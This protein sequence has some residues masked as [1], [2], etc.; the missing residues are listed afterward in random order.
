MSV[1][2]K[3]HLPSWLTKDF[4]EKAFRSYKKDESLEILSYNCVE[5]KFDNHFGSDIYCVEIIFKTP[6][7]S[8]S[9]S[10]V[11]VKLVTD[12]ASEMGEILQDSLFMRNEIKMYLKS[13]PMIND[14]LNRH[15][16]KCYY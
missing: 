5:D 16:M 14:L 11:I 15:D 9:K 6:I 3:N 2:E 4:L 1:S 13:I 8:E 7:S 10:K 12:K